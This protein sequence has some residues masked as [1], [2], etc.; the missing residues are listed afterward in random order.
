VIG[1]RGFSTS[2]VVVK[3]TP[4]NH[5]RMRQG[6][7]L[8]HLYAL[9]RMDCSL[10]RAQAGEAEWSQNQARREIGD[11]QVGMRTMAQPGMTSSYWVTSPV[12][13]PP[14]DGEKAEK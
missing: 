11:V 7:N 10:G 4:K 8:R 9:V 2:Q 3:E 13:A 5:G 12:R 6:D 14:W 1:S